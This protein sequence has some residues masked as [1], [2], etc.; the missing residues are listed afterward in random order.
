MRFWELEKFG[1]RQLPKKRFVGH[2][3]RCQ[4]KI[5]RVSRA[6]VPVQRL[7]LSLHAPAYAELRRSKRRAK[8][9]NPLIQS[10]LSILS[11][12]AWRRPGRLP[13]QPCDQLLGMLDPAVGEVTWLARISSTVISWICVKTMLDAMRTSSKLESEV[14][15]RKCKRTSPNYRKG[16]A[17]NKRR[18]GS[19]RLG[20]N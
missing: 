5:W 20:D 9:F 19:C 16:P 18:S 11:S 17:D 13:I 6:L 15:S 3:T 12:M 1:K 2:S 8:A 10:H 4:A 14:G 7:A